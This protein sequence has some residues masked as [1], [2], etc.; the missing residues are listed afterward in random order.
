VGYE[1][2]KCKMQNA[3]LKIGSRFCILH[4]AFCI[5]HLPV[6]SRHSTVTVHHSLTR[7]TFVR[8]QLLPR[9]DPRR[10]G[11]MLRPRDDPHGASP[12][13]AG[14]PAGVAEGR[15]GAAGDVEYGLI[16]LRFA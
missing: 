4:F 2:A 15:A 10:W 14:S 16:G 7:Q 8:L 1:N 3:K 5:L 9:L 6:S 13:D 12:A 11:E